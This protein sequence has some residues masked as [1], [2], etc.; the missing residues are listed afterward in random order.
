MS[1]G[2]RENKIYERYKADADRFIQRATINEDMVN[3]RLGSKRKIWEYATLGIIAAVGIYFIIDF[4]T[5]SGGFFIKLIV[6]FIMLFLFL[7][8]ANL[9]LTGSEKLGNSMMKKQGGQMYKDLNAVILSCKNDIYAEAKRRASE[10]LL[11]SDQE[12]SAYLDIF[13]GSPDVQKIA[14]SV[15]GKMKYT[16][17]LE[18]ETFTV[19]RDQIVT[20]HSNLAMSSFGFNALPSD[21]ACEALAQIVGQMLLVQMR[22]DH[23]EKKYEMEIHDRTVTY[24]EY[25]LKSSEPTLRDLA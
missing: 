1:A 10:A 13:A 17:R 15:Y 12:K 21:E 16:T 14:G 24:H 3:M 20:P 9:I 11:R 4:M 8:L 6:F 19:N 23:S 2:E 7:G 22:T 18:G 25:E 5:T